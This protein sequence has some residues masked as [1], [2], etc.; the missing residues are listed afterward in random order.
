MILYAPAKVN[1]Y[2]RILSRRPDGYHNLETVF[3]RIALCD[4]I[5]LRSLPIERRSRTDSVNGYVKIFCDN[6][7]VPT[8]VG[9]LAYRAVE[10]FKKQF[11]ISKG[12]EIK[13][14]KKIPIAS[15]LAGGSSD[16]ATILKGL[17]SL[18]GL[19]LRLP[20]LTRI[21]KRLGADVPF[22]L[23]NNSFAV[24]RNR[25]DEIKPLKWKIKL[26]HLLVTFPM[27]LLSKEIYERYA[28]GT[29][30][31][32]TKRP[33]IT[34]ILSSFSSEVTGEDI[35]AF[36]ENDLEST[37]LKKEPV[38]AE[39]KRSL[40]DLGMRHSLVSGSGPS[41]FSLF[42][43]RKEAMRARGALIKRFPVCKKKGWQIL[44]IPTI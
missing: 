15:G 37:V 33:R 4:K 34:K 3:E 1:L 14:F 25:G 30:C 24:A 17:L 9:S 36:S 7:E 11:C 5:I 21:G 6:P 8:G 10:L 13:I 27:G 22:F 42:D 29:S 41:V 31:A 23:N 20:E 38:I 18:W 28:A 40:K 12:V 2:L 35:R 26:W 39:L 16:V 19:P 32:L 43:D 44:V